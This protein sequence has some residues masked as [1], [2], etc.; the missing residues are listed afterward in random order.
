MSTRKILVVLL[1]GIGDCLMALPAIHSLKRKNPKSH[2]TVMTINKPLYHELLK[3]DTSINQLIFSTLK[4]NPHYGNPLKFF[5]EKKI[6]KEDIRKA[7]KKYDI[8]ETHF[9]KMFRTPAKLYSKLPLNYYR[10]HKTLKIAKEL[11]VTLLTQR[12]NLKYS[13]KDDAWAKTYMRRNNLRPTKLIGLHFTGSAKSKSLNYREGQ[14]IIQQLKLKGYDLVLFHDKHSYTRQEKH[15]D[16]KEV[17]TYVSDNIL[18]AAA[19]VDQCKALIC[20]DSGISHVAAAL[21]KKTFVIYFKDI[22]K[23]NSLAL[24]DEIKAYVYKKKG[25][26]LLRGIRSFLQ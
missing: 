17:A 16:P 2:I 8:V 14:R 9:V 6:I 22:W 23:W 24:G 20:V 3:Y 1:H 7:E 18:H 15:Y 10:E 13:I 21:N 19:L 25:E 12:Y 11:G 5:R 26:G 4:K